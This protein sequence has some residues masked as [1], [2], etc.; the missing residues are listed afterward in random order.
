M[1]KQ[2]KKDLTEVEIISWAIPRIAGG[3]Y[4]TSVDERGRELWV[5]EFET[6]LEEMERELCYGPDNRAEEPLRRLKE[7]CNPIN[8]RDFFDAILGEKL[9]G[10]LAE[11]FSGVD[12]T[13][14]H[15]KIVVTLG[16]RQLQNLTG[17]IQTLLTKGRESMSVDQLANLEGKADPR[18]VSVAVVTHYAKEISRLFPRMIKRAE[19]LRIVSTKEKA[20]LNVRR[21][22]EEATKCYIY[23]QFVACIIV[24]RSAT[25]FA[26]RDRLEASGKEHELRA[27]KIQKQDSL[28]GLIVFARKVFPSLKSTLDEADLIREAARNAVHLSEPSA[29]TCKDMFI[30]TRGVLREL[31]LTNS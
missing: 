11:Q 13:P 27:M 8:I 25:E 19:I 3:H 18:A 31:Y 17:S 23:G 29:D 21:Y 7:D 12:L 9:G 6:T 4:A 22:M 5:N 2:S 24:C 28:Y 15:Y 20:P 10:K 14:A 26:L 30:K 16:Y 1:S